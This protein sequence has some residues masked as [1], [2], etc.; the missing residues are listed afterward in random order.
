MLK[1]L[2]TLYEQEG[3]SDSFIGFG[4][5]VYDYENFKAGKP[6]KGSVDWNVKELSAQARL[7]RS[8]YTRAGGKLD[9]LEGS[10]KEVSEISE[11][12]KGKGNEASRL[13]RLEAREENTKSNDMRR[14]GYIHFS[15][16]GI[17]DEQ[18][19]AIDP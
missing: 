13:L 5:P 7:S 17:L 9:R 12:F 2:R 15:T 1:T 11:I 4:D 6:E 3:L 8:G 16:H 19:Q 18:F 10:G 14:Y